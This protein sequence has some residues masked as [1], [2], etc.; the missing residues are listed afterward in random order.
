AELRARWPYIVALSYAVNVH[1]CIFEAAAEL[2]RCFRCPPSLVAKRDVV[3]VSLF[4]AQL[5]ARLRDNP[6]AGKG[7]VRLA[8]L[9][10]RVPDLLLLR[11]QPQLAPVRFEFSQALQPPVQ[12]PSAF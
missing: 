7:H 10:E 3:A 2:A 5:C 9:Q 8:L 11:A 1:H 12:N 6:F 4:R